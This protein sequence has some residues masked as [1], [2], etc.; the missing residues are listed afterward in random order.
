MKM[1]IKLSATIVIMIFLTISLNLSLQSSIPGGKNSP[2]KNNDDIREIAT[3]LEQTIPILMNEVG[4]P[5]LSIALIRNNDLVW[6]ST[7]G[8]TSV[9]SG[10]PVDENTIFEAASLSKPVFAYLVLKFI[11]RGELDLDTPLI[12]Y[13][14]EDYIK[15]RF[16]GKNF[17]DDRYKKI[18]A[19][20]VLNHST[21]FPNWREGNTIDFKYEPGSKFSYSAEGFYYLQ[22][23][24]EKISGQKFT[25]LMRQEVFEPLGMT[26]SSYTW[27]PEF[28]HNSAHRHDMM[29]ENLGLRQHKRAL[30]P[31]T[32][33]TTACD[34][35]RF[36]KALMIGE[37]LDELTYR[38]MLRFQSTYSKEGYEG[39]DWGLGTGLEKSVGSICIWHWGDN[40]YAQAFYL[41]IPEQKIC[42]VYF[43]NSFYGLAL[44][45]DIVGIALGG[46]HPVMECGIMQPYI[47]LGKPIATFIQ[48]IKNKDFES[49]EDFFKK[50]IV[51]QIGHENVYN[52]ALLNEI[53]YW[54]L[55]KEHIDGA[56]RI[57]RL[58]VEAFPE[59]WNVYDSLGEAYLKDEQNDQAIKLF[60]KSLKLNPN[61]E[62]AK[63][64][65]KR[66]KE[67]ENG[68]K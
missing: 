1:V 16:L 37:G 60:N 28:G 17:N 30:G 65:I 63:N 20:M 56:I 24:I 38:E 35:A 27:Q 23:I 33:Q 52:E 59:S 18:T 14:S 21:G 8:I 4:V 9:D 39:V 19:R 58:N 49:A 5:G 47:S 50:N 61:N 6:H 67:G 22:I 54:L 25:E 3:K 2:I 48:K 42:L 68:Q 32:L 43:A 64:M 7:F 26:K 15:I 31:A 40:T 11:A 29:G 13:A 57:F 10:K 41:A 34:Y 53:G 44:A 12:D 51:L 66:I 46:E 45:K 55:K 62:N 36:L